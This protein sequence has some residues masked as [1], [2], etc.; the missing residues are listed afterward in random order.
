MAERQVTIGD[1][2]L[3]LPSPFVVLATQ[4]PI[5]HEG[6]YRLPEAELDRFFIKIL[7]GYPS[8]EEERKIVLTG[9]EEKSNFETESAKSRP[10]VFSIED[11]RALKNAAALVH[12]EESIAAYIVSLVAATRPPA[13]GETSRASLP[14]QERRMG[15]GRLKEESY[16]Q[17]VRLGA[18]PRASISLYRYAKIKAMFAGR[19]WVSPEDVKDS[20]F[21]V[22]RHRIA[23]SYE[24]ASAGVSADDVVSMILD[25]VPLP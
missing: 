14:R 4:N 1:D 6:T 5:E 2:T 3:P 9:Q 18:S 16:F 15:A 24:A 13:L 8:M 21:D 22:L 12:C 19:S 10:P 25:A 17:Y 11:L 20:A 23:L 7:I